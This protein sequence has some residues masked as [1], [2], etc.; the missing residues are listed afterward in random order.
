M[1]FQLDII[2][3]LFYEMVADDR[4]SVFLVGLNVFIE[5]NTELTTLGL[6]PAIWDGVSLSSPSK[7][8]VKELP[9]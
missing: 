3:P 5:Q 9:G 8:K 4:L 6:F 7:S 1:S 2:R